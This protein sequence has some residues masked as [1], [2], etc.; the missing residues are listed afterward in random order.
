MPSDFWLQLPAVGRSIR[1]NIKRPWVVAGI[2]VGLLPAVGVLIATIAGET[3][4]GSFLI[5]LWD[6]VTE[7][8]KLPIRR[9]ALIWL[10]S[11]TVW[12]ALL[13]LVVL[14]VAI[15]RSR[16]RYGKRKELE[17]QVSAISREQDRLEA[18]KEGLRQL[19]QYGRAWT[20]VSPM[21]NEYDRKILTNAARG[22]A[23]KL[24][25]TVRWAKKVWGELQGRTYTPAQDTP[26]SMIGEQINTVELDHIQNALSDLN[27]SLSP[28]YPERDP[29]APLVSAYIAYHEWRKQLLRFAACFN[30]PVQKL[31]AYRK[32]FEAEAKFDE[33]LWARA[34]DTD[35]FVDVSSG[36]ALYVQDH[37][38]DPLPPPEG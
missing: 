19:N 24:D 5:R 7:W 11:T 26:A 33:V 8:S 36:A 37:K 13:A 23:V 14:V 18:E 32:W 15:W 16:T 29:R 27:A 34:Q 20:R 1:A 28:E 12:F 25:E 2:L 17:Q 3:A 22:V 31:T 9:V 30:Q 4:I 10:M 35:Q 6:H 38:P 21:A